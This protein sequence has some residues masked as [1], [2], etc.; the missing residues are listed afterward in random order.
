MVSAL[1]LSA[2]ALVH[3]YDGSV[4]LSREEAQESLAIFQ[5]LQWAAGMIWPLWALGFVE[6]SLGN[7]AAVDAI[8]GPLATG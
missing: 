4:D 3:A 7:F 2:T 5:E 1:A 8:L 6:L